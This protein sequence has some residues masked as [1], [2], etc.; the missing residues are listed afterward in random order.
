M[1]IHMC[2][3]LLRH[4][5]LFL[6]L[7]TEDSDPKSRMMLTYRYGCI[8]RMLGVLSD[9]VHY[10]WYWEWIS[11]GWV[12]IFLTQG[13][14]A[15]EGLRFYAGIYKRHY[16]RDRRRAPLLQKSN[17]L[18]IGAL[19]NRL[20]KWSTRERI[21]WIYT[22]DERLWSYTWLL[23]E[24]LESFCPFNRTMGPRTWRAVRRLEGQKESATENSQDQ[25]HIA[26]RPRIWTRRVIAQTNLFDKVY[27]FQHSDHNIL[28]RVNCCS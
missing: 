25:Q 19:I 5:V 14:D 7:R 27:W 1:T 17:I 3:T 21:S 10:A 28:G 11:G 12:D 2:C 9:I 22:K 23:L 15:V 24:I 8:F 26:L 6:I 16:L 18:Y 4:Y 13:L 20:N